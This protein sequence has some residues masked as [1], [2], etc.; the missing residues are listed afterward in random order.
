MPLTAGTRLG[1][2]EILAPIGAGGMGEVYRARDS[3][4]KRDVA[5]KVLPQHLASDPQRMARFEREAQ[6]LACVN[7][8]NIASIY[9]LEESSD[10][11]ALV[12]ELVEGL[13]LAER[14]ARGPLPLNEALAIGR[15][16]TEALEYA[17]EHGIVHRDLKPANVK[18]TADD[19]V[20]V[21]DFGLA[22]AL[23]DELPLA[24]SSTSPT[25]TAVATRSGII[26]GTAGYMSPEQARGRAVDRRTD[27]WAFGCVLFEMLTGKLAF[28]GETATDTLAAVLTKEPELEHLPASTPASI[29]TLIGRCLQKQI[30]RRVQAIGDARID[31]EDCL[32]R[33]EFGRSCTAWARQYSRPGN[34]K[35][36]KAMASFRDLCRRFR[37]DYGGFPCVAAQTGTSKEPGLDGRHDC[38]SKHLDGATHFSRR[39]HSRLPGHDR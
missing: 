26:L 33:E 34:E 2:Y 35:A 12:M 27:V 8:P 1:P 20:K 31:I 17:H 19:L 4:L 38:R 16:I 30:R 22:K 32:I 15:Q 3:R 25:L 39:P 7:H 10:I 13:T 29:R 6:L 5:L 11:R 36:G 18:L 14:V 24:D 21:L 9:G 28:P 23:S 37:H